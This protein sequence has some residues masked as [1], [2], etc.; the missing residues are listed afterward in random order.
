MGN[1]RHGWK[2]SFNPEEVYPGCVRVSTVP[3]VILYPEIS[4]G[5]ETRVEKISKSEALI[6]FM[7]HSMVLTNKETASRHFDIITDLIHTSECYILKFGSDMD[8][9]KS[10]VESLL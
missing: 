9:L 6:R 7:P 2:K 10:V 1:D 8:V 3:K 4:R 5:G